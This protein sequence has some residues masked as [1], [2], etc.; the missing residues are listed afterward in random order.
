MRLTNGFTLIE[1]LIL[2]FILGIL[3]TLAIPSF[4]HSYQR[5]TLSTTAKD[6]L[7]L[8][9]LAQSTAKSTDT[10][11]RLTFT[12]DPNNNITSIQTQMPHKVTKLDTPETISI[13][14]KITLTSDLVFTSINFNSNGSW[15]IY[16]LE[17]AINAPVLTLTFTNQKT[18]QQILFYAE[19]QM[20]HLQKTA[21]H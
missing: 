17:T 9:Q 16:A 10:P 12:R 1:M 6:V 13:P 4:Y 18:I 3:S 20:I 8:C 11:I 19:S 14:E 21:S 7:A 5:L 2:L 15:T